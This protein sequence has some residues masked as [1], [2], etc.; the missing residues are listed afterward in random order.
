MKQMNKI[1]IIVLTC[2]ALL[3]ASCMNPEKNNFSKVDNPKENQVVIDTANQLKNSLKVSEKE[4]INGWLK[5]SVK[6]QVVINKIGNPEKKGEDEY[7]GAIGTYV[8]NWEYPALGINL[9]MESEYQ[10]G[11]KIVK[12]ITIVKPC[13]L[14]TL[15][16]V[17]IDS[18]IKLIKEKYSE[19]IDAS[20]SDSNTIVVGSIYDG[21]IFTIKDGAVCKIF[22]GA[23]A[24]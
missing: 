16:G 4:V 20:N 19:L 9:E 1:K 23:A 2:S 15:K 6:Q 21:T 24:E 12:S 5:V 8:Q 7:W 10:G 14:T 22:I 13:K 11:D 17:S 18:D 3:I